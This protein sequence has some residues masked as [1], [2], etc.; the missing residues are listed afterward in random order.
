MSNAI[1]QSPAVCKQWRAK[2]G[3]SPLR[4]TSKTIKLSPISRTLRFNYKLMGLGY[5]KLS[6]RSRLV[7][8]ATSSA[9][10]RLRHAAWQNTSRW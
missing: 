4:D 5:G 6:T 9:S 3:V 8:Q 10:Y 7:P 2:G 1:G